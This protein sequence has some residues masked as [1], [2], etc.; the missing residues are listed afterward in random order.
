MKLFLQLLLLITP[1][2]ALRAEEIEF[3]EEELSRESVLPVFETRTDVLHRH[4]ETTRRF[5]FGGGG[6][7]EINE[8]FYSD[9]IFSAHG[10]YHFSN[11]HGVNVEGIYWTTGLSDYGKQ[12]KHD[13]AFDPNRAPHPLWGV[14]GNYEFTAYYGKI[15]LTKQTV[16][17]LNF[18]FYGG[19]LYI[20]MAGYNAFG[21]DIGLGQNYFITPQ[22]ALRLDLRMMIFRGPNAA[23]YD[24][25]HTTGPVSASAFPQKFF[26]N[27][28]AEVS[29]VFLL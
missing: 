26:F 19:P 22:V 5:E 27:N 12:I 16:M 1:L 8:P 9:A 2:C 6:G 29:V 14:V 25:S 3:P 23:S 4:V 10:G 7:L 28:H 15:S 24:L 18:V 17:N 13:W 20:N 11:L 21:G